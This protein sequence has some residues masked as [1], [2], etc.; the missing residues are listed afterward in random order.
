MAARDTVFRP[1]RGAHLPDLVDREPV[2]PPTTMRLGRRRQ[3]GRPAARPADR[4]A[5]S[6]SDRASRL[7]DNLKS[8]PQPPQRHPAWGSLLPEDSARLRLGPAGSDVMLVDATADEVGRPAASYSSTLTLTCCSGNGPNPCDSCGAVLS[9]PP[10]N[11]LFA[12]W[13]E[14][15]P[16]SF[17][18]ACFGSLSDESA[19][20]DV[21]PGRRRGRAC[22]ARQ[23]TGVSSLRARPSAGGCSSASPRRTHRP[24]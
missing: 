19:Q 7:P 18:I 6:P 1:E 10:G 22:G 9:P 3:S 2:E 13:F 11:R 8:E 23:S 4:F 24:G 5:L 21:R 12:A 17:Q 14:S 15:N 20:R 16:G